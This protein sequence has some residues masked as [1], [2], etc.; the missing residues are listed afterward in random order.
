MCHI[1]RL[2][3]FVAARETAEII[4]SSGKG[5]LPFPELVSISSGRTARKQ[6]HRECFT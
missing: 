6:L 2:P 3:P 5:I 1:L 4:K